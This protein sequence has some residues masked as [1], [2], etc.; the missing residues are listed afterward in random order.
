M[1]QYGAISEDHIYS[2]SEMAEFV[3]YSR[4]RGVKI[5]PELDA[6]SHAG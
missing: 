5:I 4:I 6:P 1:T 3:K 2:P